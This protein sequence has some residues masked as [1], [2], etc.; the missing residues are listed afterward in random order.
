MG[1]RDFIDQQRKYGLQNDL[2]QAGSR[3]AHRNS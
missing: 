1:H 3:K 2:G